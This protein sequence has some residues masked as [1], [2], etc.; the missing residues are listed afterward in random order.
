MEENKYYSWPQ[1]GSEIING[2]TFT[3]KFHLFQDGFTGNPDQ[4]FISIQI[5]E[6]TN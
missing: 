2:F 6:C 3:G 4:N 5:I 1:D